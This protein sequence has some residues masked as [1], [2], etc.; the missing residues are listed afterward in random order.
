MK[1][2]RQLTGQGKRLAELL[3]MQF[4]GQREMAEFMGMSQPNLWRY[5]QMEVLPPLFW[6]NY[7]GRLAEAGLNAGYITD[8]TNHAPMFEEAAEAYLAKVVEKL[9][10]RKT[11]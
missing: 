7:G 11:A 1:K 8:P 2:E 5:F 6:K 9:K 4:S 3:D 10:L